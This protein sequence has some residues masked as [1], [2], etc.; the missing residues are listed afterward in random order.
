MI[1]YIIKAVSSTVSSVQ[2]WEIETFCAIVTLIEMVRNKSDLE[3]DGRDRMRK[4]CCRV[5]RCGQT[6]TLLDTETGV[7]SAEK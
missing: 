1:V 7:A 6:N 3:K 4:L 5:L 2:F